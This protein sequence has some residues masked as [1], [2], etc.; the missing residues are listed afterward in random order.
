MCSVMSDSATPCPVAHQV[1]LSMGSPRQ[2]NWSGLPFPHPG[3]LL[4]PGIKPMSPASP[5]LAGG[6]FT[7]EPPGKPLYILYTH[8]YITTINIFLITEKKPEGQRTKKPTGKIR[9][10]FVQV[11]H[12]EMTKMALKCKKNVETH[13]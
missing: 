1:P 2:E 8:T 12:K 7:T 4:D 6:F 11:V 13:S 10:I 5:A 3:D 9:K